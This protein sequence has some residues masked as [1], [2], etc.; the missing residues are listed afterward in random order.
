VTLDGDARIEAPGKDAGTAPL[1]LQGIAPP[2]AW[3]DLAAATR[4]VA[5]DPRTT[6]E[7]TFRGPA[8]VRMCAGFAEESWI[9]SG[10]FQSSVG[11]GES[12][13][14]EEWVVTPSGVVRY[15]AADVSVEVMRHGAEVTLT[16]GVA[17]AWGI[18]IDDASASPD[19]GWR[20]LP[21]GKTHLATH[22][23]PVSAAVGRCAALA[24]SARDL[25]AQVMAPDGGA[26]GDTITRQVST[27]RLAR[28][29][30]AVVTLRVSALPPG[31]AA[32]LLRP[33]ADANSAWSGLPMGL[34]A[35]SSG[36]PSP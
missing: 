21:T 23:E 7:T 30:C 12:P 6:R 33:V 28:A 11:A 17:F 34:P 36:L 3:I 2:D 10:S 4:V 15:T 24:A 14:E 22:E 26:A 32:S 13:G 35:S 19:E 9:A 29:A 20:R 1:L 31:N 25:A 18:E 27:R 5:R 8:R 16:G